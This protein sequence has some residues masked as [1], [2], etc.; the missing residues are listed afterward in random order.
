MAWPLAEI[1]LLEFQEVTNKALNSHFS[2]L[3][4]G[5]SPNGRDCVAGLMNPS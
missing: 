5:A 3:R 4:K 1:E 2:P